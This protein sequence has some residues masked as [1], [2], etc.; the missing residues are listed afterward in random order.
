MEKAVNQKGLVVR[1]DTPV[2]KVAEIRL[3]KH[4]VWVLVGTHE[5]IS[6]Q[7]RKILDF[8]SVILLVL[9]LALYDRK[10]ALCLALVSRLIL[11]DIVY[12]P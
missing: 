4:L 1:Q 2:D 6:H 3:L 10:E 12:F 7:V 8:V 11:R 9:S 5:K